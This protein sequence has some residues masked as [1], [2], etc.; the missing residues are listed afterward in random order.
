MN[1][2]ELSSALAKAITAFVFALLALAFLLPTG[3]LW[4][5]YM[6]LRNSP[7]VSSE[8]LLTVRN[9]YFVLIL[10]FGIISFLSGIAA[11]ILHHRSAA[12]F[13]YDDTA[14]NQR[15][16]AGKLL[17][18]IAYPLGI[19]GTLASLLLTTLSSLSLYNFF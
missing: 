11:L 4:G 1:P 5:V 6:I 7:S 13:A 16:Q 2:E 8:D 10:V 15:Y 12:F 14:K 17:S 3:I 19:L 9:V 18:R